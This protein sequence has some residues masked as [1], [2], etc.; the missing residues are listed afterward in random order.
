MEGNESTSMEFF[1]MVSIPRSGA[2]P[3]LIVSHELLACDLDVPPDFKWKNPSC[4]ASLP[5]LSLPLPPPA[6][7]HRCG[8]IGFG[9]GLAIYRICT[10]TADLTGTPVGKFTQYTNSSGAS[11]YRVNIKLQISLVDEML[12]FEL[13]FD[14]KSCGEVTAKFE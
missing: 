1:R 4:T 10:L 8:L 3:C 5:P 12:K 11:Y 6:L 9:D 2:P 13:L 7:V 14:G